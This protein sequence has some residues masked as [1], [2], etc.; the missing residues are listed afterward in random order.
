MKRFII[1]L[2]IFFLFIFTID[3]LFIPIR[4][5]AADLE[6][7]KR[8]EN[9]IQGK[10]NKDLIVIGSS[11]GARNISAGYIGTN[12]NMSSFNISYPGSNVLFHDFLLDLYLKHNEKP[13]ILVWSI[14]DCNELL[15]APHLKFRLDRLYPLVKYPE[16]RK[17]LVEKGEKNAILSRLFVLHQM[18][19]SNFSFKKVTPNR[20]DTVQL[21][22]SML[23]SFQREDRKWNYVNDDKYDATTEEKDKQ[24]AF[25][26]IIKRCEKEGI[27]L[28]VVVSPNYRKTRMTFV[29]RMQSLIANRAELYVCNQED[30][31]YKEKPYFHDEAH[32]KSNGALLFSQEIV[33][34]LKKNPK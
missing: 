7:D 26:N 20:F 21:D 34:Y 9:I 3:K 27:R 32:L 17:V 19:L 24:I 12:L 13:K 5:Q 8:L 1:R 10:I 4:N 31:R 15:Y 25:E 33:D 11:R 28:V 16:V 29:K 14:D 18:S 22:G 6:Y 30:K 23:I 2:I